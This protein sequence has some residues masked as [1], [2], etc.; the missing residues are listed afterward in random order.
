MKNT[1]A[2]SDRMVLDHN[3]VPTEYGKSQTV[4]SQSFTVKELIEMQRKG[5]S[6]NVLKKALYE[7]DDFGENMNPLRAKNF[8]LTD[9]DKITQ[10]VKRHR[11]KIEALE[12]K[13]SIKKKQ[14]ER[15]QIIKEY[16]EEKDKDKDGKL[17]SKS[18]PPTEGQSV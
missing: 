6:P 14:E 4:P 17:D 2:I 12:K 5:I 3:H 13:R 7:M 1:Y 10:T 9:M 11:D 18:E 15:N 8:D 16:L